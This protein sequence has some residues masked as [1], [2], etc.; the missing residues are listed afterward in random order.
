MTGSSAKSSWFIAKIYATR[1][2]GSSES[3]GASHLP[4][5]ANVLLFDLSRVKSYGRKVAVVAAFPL[6]FAAR[7]IDG[8]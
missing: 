4:E 2:S 6:A 7:M 3:D 8:G 1:L 5:C